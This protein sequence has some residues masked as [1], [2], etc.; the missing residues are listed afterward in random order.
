MEQ[1]LNKPQ[2]PDI[3]IFV[4]HR[5]D[6]DSEMIDNPLYYPVRC[7][8]V[9]DSRDNVTMLGDNTGDNISE[10]RE[11][12]CELT[13]QYWA[14]KNVE[15][16]Y[17]GLCHYR[18][19][20]SF[21][22]EN[23][24]VDSR[25]QIVEKYIYEDFIE[26]YG[27]ASEKIMR[28]V[29]EANDVVI[30]KSMN[31]RNVWT[32]N[33]YKDTVYKHWKAHNKFLLDAEALDMLNEVIKERHPKY[34][35]VFQDYMNGEYFLGYNC[36]II[37]KQLFNELCE[38]EFDVLF[39]LERKINSRYK[40][41]S[42]NMKRTC[43]FMGEI[44]YS[45]YVQYL[46]KLGK[47]KI[48]E[49]PIV[50]IE[51]VDKQVKIS[52]L[53]EKNNIPIV[54]VANDNNVLPLLVTLE[55]LLDN[56]SQSYN[57]DLIIQEEHLSEEYHNL[58]S[59]MCDK[60]KNISLR[61]I[62]IENISDIMKKRYNMPNFG[63]ANMM[64]ICQPWIMEE[65]DKILMFSGDIIFCSDPADLYGE[66]I[67]KIYVAGVCDIIHQARMN[68]ANLEYAKHVK[69]TGLKDPYRY[70]NIDSLICN[71]SLIRKDFSIQEIYDFAKENKQGNEVEW[72][73][74]L[75]QDKIR[76][77]D[78]KWNYYED[79]NEIVKYYLTFAPAEEVNRNKKSRENKCIVNYY[80]Y[81]KPYE[82]FGYNDT[83]FWHYARKSL[84]Y[85]IIVNNVI[86][87]KLLAN[88]RSFARKC[89]DKWLPVGSKRRKF[90]KSFMPRGS[91]QWR[92]LKRAYD[93]IFFR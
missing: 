48:K 68:E 24:K 37:K 21:S 83:L 13:V 91:L 89:A 51:H 52:P 69:E 5:I 41:Y 30:A 61:F 6:L 23:F 49:V 57:Y 32:P 15:A 47:Y 8:A 71:L 34:Y 20:L 55:S 88:N 72:L 87:H 79:T 3:K 85:E 27:I 76:M 10:K 45:I 31:V 9:Y 46:R 92:I 67:E 60:Y 86:H 65:Y 1:V 62:K 63:L 80:L 2:E 26:K 66:N 50:F 12:F 93:L 22:D 38:F 19:F 33:G 53:F 54:F 4:S 14:W 35:D 78:P 84:V 81:P 90:V 36:F 16:D 74:A 39:E 7:G 28:N 64:H 40:Y 77:L 70:I 44:L 75:F 42:A 58:M 59:S 25:N 29:I 73:N 17:Y 18:R 56:I 11:S 82:Y 43:G